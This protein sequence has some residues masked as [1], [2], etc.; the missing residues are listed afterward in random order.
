VG[1]ASE[2]LTHFLVQAVGSELEK[3]SGGVELVVHAVDLVL[4]YGRAFG[5]FEDEH[6]SLGL[7]S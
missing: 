2:E 5:I 1:G 4:S 3:V 6:Q 7:L